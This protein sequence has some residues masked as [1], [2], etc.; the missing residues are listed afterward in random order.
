MI[1]YVLYE[2]SIGGGGK[3][4]LTDFQD[5]KMCEALRARRTSN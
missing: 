4:L 2:K 1:K 5:E 3:A